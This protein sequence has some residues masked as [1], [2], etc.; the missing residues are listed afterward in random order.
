MAVLIPDME[1]P[2]S[3]CECPFFVEV[4]CVAG[5][6]KFR[7]DFFDDKFDAC[8]ERHPDCPLTEMVLCGDCRYAEKLHF[9]ALNMYHCKY[10]GDVFDSV[11]NTCSM[12]ERKK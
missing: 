8:R 5:N 1:I 6:A 12:G 7:E 10:H 4:W 3:C 9:K 11:N 2:T